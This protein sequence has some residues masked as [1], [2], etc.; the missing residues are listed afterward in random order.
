M[1]FDDYQLLAHTTAEYPPVKGLE[2]LTLKLCSEAGEVAGKVGK[3]FRG[4]YDLN[5]EIKKQLQDE[6][7]D[8]LWYLA[9]L[10]TYL[11]VRLMHVAVENTKKLENRKKR[12]RIKG[13]G[14][15]R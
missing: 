2:Y 7:G 14:D 3:H 5:Q 13:D 9:E 6:L 4:D 12:G 8:V 15:N 10:C 11:D 1:D